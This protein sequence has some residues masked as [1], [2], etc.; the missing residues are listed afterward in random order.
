M[1]KSIIPE[2]SLDKSD[3]EFMVLDKKGQSLIDVL[4]SEFNEE[5]FS[6]SKRIGSTENITALKGCFDIDICL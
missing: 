1:F 4:L 3:T 2:I 6:H 5:L